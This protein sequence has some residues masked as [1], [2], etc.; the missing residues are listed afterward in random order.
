MH[1]LYCRTDI[2]V[3][4]FVHTSYEHVHREVQKIMRWCPLEAEGSD[5]HAHDYQILKRYNLMTDAYPILGLG[6]KFLLT[7]SITQVTCKWRFSTLKY[8]K[9]RLR[10][11]LSQEH[12]E[13]FMLMATK[14]D[15]LMALDTDMVID[16]CTEGELLR[17]LLIQ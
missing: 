16:S 7:L 3:H 4:L 6:Y 13:A 15:I 5:M 10:S 11:N 17:K 2:G 9:G 12:Q 14:K 8:I 1:F